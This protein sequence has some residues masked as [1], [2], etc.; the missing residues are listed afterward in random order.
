MSYIL[1]CLDSSTPGTST[2]CARPH[3]FYE[4]PHIG[5]EGWVSSE[6]SAH[7][8]ATSLCVRPEWLNHW[9]KT[10]RMRFPPSAGQQPFSELLLRGDDHAR[11]T[12]AGTHLAVEML[13]LADVGGDHVDR[14]MQMSRRVDERKTERTQRQEIRAFRRLSS[15]KDGRPAAHRGRIPRRGGSSARDEAWFAGAIVQARRAPHRSLQHDRTPG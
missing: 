4:P 12:G 13:P 7:D 14:P 5:F 9:P 2:Y 10:D 6:D 15:A 11:R 8:A 3:P 1:D